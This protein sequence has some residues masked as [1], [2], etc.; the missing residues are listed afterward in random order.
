MCIKKHT[1]IRTLDTRNA[2]GSLAGNWF[3]PLTHL[4]LSGAAF[5]G[6]TE[7][8]QTFFREKILP[9]GI[10]SNLCKKAVIYWFLHKK[11]PVKTSLSFSTYSLSG[12]PG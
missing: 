11:R 6:F 3:Q 7:V 8:S 12:L 10:L 9:D 4:S 2:Y 1:M 5:Y